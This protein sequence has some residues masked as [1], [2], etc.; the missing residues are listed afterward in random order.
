M[1][2]LDGGCSSPIAVNCTLSSG[3]LQL[4]GAVFSVDGVESMYKE[5][6]VDL[7]NVDKS[8]GSYEKAYTGIIVQNIEPY[9][10]AA[11]F[12]LG[13]DVARSLLEDGAGEI[14]A[15][16]KAANKP[17]NNPGIAPDLNR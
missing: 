3:K 5:I 12:Q 7:N 15:V 9:K 10:M 16:A 1:K 8:Y 4:L 13:V 14:I 2:Y 17:E 11:A 6:T